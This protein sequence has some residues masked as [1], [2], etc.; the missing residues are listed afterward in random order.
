MSLHI[1]TAQ[2]VGVSYEVASI[3]DRIVAQLIDYVIYVVWFLGGV[4]LLSLA[5]LGATWQVIAGVL[6]P[7]MCYPLLCEY[8]LNGQTLGKMALGIRVVMLDGS[9]PALSAYLMRWLL[10]IV[11]ISLFSGLVAVLAIV[12]TGKGQ[13]VGD[14]AAGTAVIKMK[15]FTRFQDTLLPE[16]PADY[17]PS[18]YGVS[19]LSDRDIATLKKVLASRHPE[20]LEA[21]ARRMEEL[22]GILRKEEASAFLKTL[23][24][25]HHYLA[26]QE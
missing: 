2:N 12:I 9:K 6:L 22:L 8:F 25:D 19:L 15:P 23:I 14:I 11:D 16:L 7:I 5:G 1:T 10:A 4:S 20:A 3:G 18:Y 17:T 13:R 24:T 21:A 26:D